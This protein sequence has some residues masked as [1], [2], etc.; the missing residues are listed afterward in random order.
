MKIQSSKF[1]RLNYNSKC[2]TVKRKQEAKMRML[3]SAGND[4]KYRK[5]LISKFC[6]D[7]SIA[8]IIIIMVK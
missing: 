1:V 3:V 2:D 7:E 5:S 8:Q 6:K 4:L